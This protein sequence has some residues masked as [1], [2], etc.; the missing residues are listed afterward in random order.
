MQFVTLRAA[1]RGDLN[2]TIQ[3]IGFI[4]Q[5]TF[6][7]GS[8]FSTWFFNAW[9]ELTAYFNTLNEIQWAVLAVCAVVFGF[10]QRD[11]SRSA[12]AEPIVRVVSRQT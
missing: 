4:M 7:N 11:F 10:R 2:D 8:S 1:A 5:T 3:G 6:S 9:D 12:R